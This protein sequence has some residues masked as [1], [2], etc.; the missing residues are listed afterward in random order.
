MSEREGKS[1]LIEE[2][3]QKNKEHEEGEKGMTRRNFLKRSVEISMGVTAAVL[4]ADMLVKHMKEKDEKALEVQRKKLEEMDTADNAQNELTENPLSG[5][6]DYQDWENQN[7]FAH[8]EEKQN[9]QEYFQSRK[10]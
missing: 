9:A 5:Y 8:P 1:P 3:N 10:H 7:P 6:R 4:G 2:I